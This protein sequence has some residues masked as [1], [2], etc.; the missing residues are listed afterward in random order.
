[1]FKM[2]YS[3]CKKENCIKIDQK[4]KK[5]YVNFIVIGLNGQKI[6]SQSHGEESSVGL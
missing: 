6:Q 2:P 3:K 1:M 4:S 5:K